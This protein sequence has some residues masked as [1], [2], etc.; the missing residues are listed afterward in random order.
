MGA[1]LFQTEYRA[2]GMTLLVIGTVTLLV[3]LA[4]ASLV[5]AA[6]GTR[7]GRTRALRH[8]GP[9][10]EPL[11]PTTVNLHGRL[12]LQQPRGMPYRHRAVE[13]TTGVRGVSQSPRT[14]L[15]QKAPLAGGAEWKRP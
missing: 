3:I 9:A 15:P 1:L 13:E 12:A 4:A 5:H 6:G 14:T 8:P 7:T 11:A 2:N 10:V